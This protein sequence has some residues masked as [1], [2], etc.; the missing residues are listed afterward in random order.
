[1]ILHAC[2]LPDQA[3]DDRRAAAAARQLMVVVNAKARKNRLSH[4][5]HC[6][7]MCWCADI[8]TRSR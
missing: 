1:M 2:L 4:A 3:E 5:L 8:K 7:L 6:M